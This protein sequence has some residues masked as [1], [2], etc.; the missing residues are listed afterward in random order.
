[1]DDINKNSN[2]E[3]VYN[4]LCVNC[5]NALTCIF[6]GSSEKPVA[7]CE[8][9]EC[10]NSISGENYDQ[11]RQQKTVRRQKNSHY[12]DHIYKGLCVNC[13]E[14]YMCRFPKPEGGVWH[15]EEYK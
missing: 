11:I 10:M 1:M 15:C 12:E 13:E 8:E 9:Y 3:K 2:K 5:K 14:R 4:G 6:A 7:Q